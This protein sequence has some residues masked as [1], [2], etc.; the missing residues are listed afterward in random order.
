MWH[1]VKLWMYVSRSG[2]QRCHFVMRNVNSCDHANCIRII[3]KTN[4]SNLLFHD[5]VKERE[6]EIAE[7]K[8][9]EECKLSW[10]KRIEQSLQLQTGKHWCRPFHPISRP[11]FPPFYG[12]KKK[13][14][15]IKVRNSH[16]HPLKIEQSNQ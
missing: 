5:Q 8:K 1:Y 12:F 11:P 2:L 4:I 14:C 16:I 13:K 6:R 9:K 15:F 7:E 10:W 3:W